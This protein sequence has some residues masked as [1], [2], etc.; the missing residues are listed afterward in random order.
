MKYIVFESIDDL[1]RFV[2]SRRATDG[3]VPAWCTSVHVTPKDYRLRF[4]PTDW[5][6]S[7]DRFGGK[8]MPASEEFLTLDVSRLL[9]HVLI[10]R[11][12]TQFY[13]GV[14]SIVL[15]VPVRM[16][17]VSAAQ[18]LLY[19]AWQQVERVEGVRSAFYSFRNPEGGGW[20]VVQIDGVAPGF[21][22][23]KF[24]QAN[25][26]K[27]TASDDRMRVFAP[28]QGFGGSS[29]YVEW[30]YRYPR[31]IAFSLLH[32]DA[33]SPLVLC[34]ADREA[35][36][37]DGKR[38]WWVPGWHVFDAED[39]V[40]V[41][42]LVQVL[43]LEKVQ[44]IH[45]EQDK[46][47]LSHVPLPLG[48]RPLSES[49]VSAHDL[50]SRI[51]ALKRELE[52]L[53]SKHERFER[54]GFQEYFPIYRWRQE[55]GR[56]ALPSGLEHM[57]G[58]PLSELARYLY[59]QTRDE[60]GAI[61]HYV[62]GKDHQS[63][64]LA[65][66]VACD[67]LYL[68]DT[69]WLNWRLP[70]FVR[71]G[72]AL[73]IDINEEE[74]AAK[75]RE[76]LPDEPPPNPDSRAGESFCLAQ[77]SGDNGHPAFAWLTFSM[78]L[79]EAVA[80]TNGHAA[81]LPRAAG[82][83]GFE[84]DA[85]A[86]SQ[87]VAVSVVAQQLDATTR[88]RTEEQLR[89]QGENW[90]RAR[91]NLQAAAFQVRLAELATRPMIAARDALLPTWAEFVQRVLEADVTALKFKLD[92]LKEWTASEPKRM[93]LLKDHEKGL[94]DTAA[95]IQQRRQEYEEILPRV[96]EKNTQ[97]AKECVAL[98]E[99]R[100]VVTKVLGELDQKTEKLAAVNA[101]LDRQN[102]A[103]EGN[104]RTTQN[105]IRR[106]DELRKKFED[107]SQSLQREKEQL[108][109][110][111]DSLENDLNL[112]H[113]DEALLVQGGKILARASTD[114]KERIDRLETDI[115]TTANEITR[116]SALRTKF[117]NLSKSLQNEK[118][119]LA[120]QVNSLEQDFS[121][122]HQDEASLAHGG[123]TLARADADLLVRLNR[124]KKAVKDC[125]SLIRQHADLCRRV[126]A[127][128]LDYEKAE[129]ALGSSKTEIET[130]LTKLRSKLKAG[131]DLE[132]KLAAGLSA[133][134]VVAEPQT[135]SSAPTKKH[136]WLF[137]WRRKHQ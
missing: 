50:E 69:R 93:D 7:G 71:Q 92:A 95:I 39:Y 16:A 55:P 107:L 122:V 68:C 74:M 33:S 81:G 118:E 47:G 111:K 105:E 19:D 121:L 46:Q 72:A 54:A 85:A 27:F 124:M 61:I 134:G 18:Q 106:H 70:L 20:Q 116:Y 40:S 101:D 91:C 117:D 108:A 99:K 67:E 123:K 83:A 112:V 42:D 79:D 103:L 76:V 98:D 3:R 100:E 56:E 13:A 73:T 65:S 22:F 26:P 115:K 23:D 59:L 126:A 12:S 135:S 131:H 75:V 52:I 38:A 128:Q 102:T 78:T 11:V 63:A 119:E 86:L 53:A 96:Q 82:A 15:A 129:Q 113:H 84:A 104:L 114:L 80:I 6:E 60:D 125:N 34:T 49:M 41:S 87:D 44:S 28:A 77:P 17:D 4:S 89:E 90:E 1:F 88:S 37:R 57:L 25:R 127:C 43:P 51:G 110:Q 32:R 8:I 64:G 58:Q 66:A 45:Y 136:T 97:L 31:P 21:D 36:T 9:E 137:F 62:A 132:A 30:E 24:R 133:G 94:T 14:T 29:L 48:I 35:E 130:V 2:L 5:G 10:Q 120:R 109:R